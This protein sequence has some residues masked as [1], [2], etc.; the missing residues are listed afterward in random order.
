[1][2]RRSDGRGG[3]AGDDAGEQKSVWHATSGAPASLDV[4]GGV[5]SRAW[6]G[7]EREE[8]QFCS[9]LGIIIVLAC[10]VTTTPPLIPSCLHFAGHL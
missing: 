8:L 7:E 4:R 9:R 1:M 2:G 3:R 10:W 5:W 6:V